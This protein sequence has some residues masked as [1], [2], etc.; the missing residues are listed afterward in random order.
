MATGFRF[1]DG[2][3]EAEFI[4]DM[5]T[6]R[7]LDESQLTELVE[8][9]LRFLSAADASALIEGAQ[10]YAERHGINTGVLKTTMRALLLFFKGAARKHLTHVLVKEDLQRFNLEEEKAAAVATLWHSHLL[11]LSRN[12]ADQTLSV[13]KLLDM[14]W[15]FGVSSSSSE[16]QQVGRTFLELRLQVEKGEGQSE[17]KVMELSLSQFYALLQ[18]MEKAKASMEFLS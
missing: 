9:C 1:S 17:S 10:E 5:K 3:V 12:I 13:N 2:S 16:L 18:E 6:L 11:V 15:R 4:E 14:D 8:L 7:A